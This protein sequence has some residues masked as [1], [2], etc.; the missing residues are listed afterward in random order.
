MDLGDE[1]GGDEGSISKNK[2]E[3]HSDSG[4][5]SPS[6]SDLGE[7]ESNERV[8]GEYEDSFGNLSEDEGVSLEEL[9]ATWEWRK[10][11][12]T[13]TGDKVKRYFLGM[14]EEEQKKCKKSEGLQL[15]DAAQLWDQ[16]APCRW[17]GIE[18]MSDEVV[19]HEQWCEYRP[20]EL[21]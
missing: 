2:D 6:H 1:S 17:C 10:K 19:H 14:N 16:L 8:L 3:R 21:L 4:V 5:G 9:I 18:G 12:F 20:M 7:Y 15:M 11:D 13:E